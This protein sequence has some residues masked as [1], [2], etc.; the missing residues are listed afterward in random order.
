MSC[1]TK[2]ISKYQ[3]Y[4]FYVYWVL[5]SYH[6]I[7]RIQYTGKIVAQNLSPQQLSPQATANNIMNEISLRHRSL[8]YLY[9]YIFQ[10]MGKI[11]GCSYPTK[12][13]HHTKSPDSVLNIMP[14][15]NKLY[16]NTTRSLCN[17]DGQ[18]KKGLNSIIILV[19]G[20]SGIITIT[21]CLM[22]LPPT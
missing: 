17:C 4:F 8:I 13:Y 22:G 14:S 21:V 11:I 1:P 2:L 18:I 16:S 12:L 6:F 15:F 7:H 9:I 5:V 10:Q 19:A 20:Q 3:L